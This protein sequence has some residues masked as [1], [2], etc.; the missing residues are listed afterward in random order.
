MNEKLPS[1]WANDYERLVFDP[2]CLD[3]KEIRKQIT[4]IEPDHPV[5]NLA[6][7]HNTRSSMKERQQQ[8][9]D[10]RQNALRTRRNHERVEAE[11]RPSFVETAKGILPTNKW[12]LA[13]GALSLAVL[14]TGGVV[15]F[16]A[17]PSQAEATPGTVAHRVVQNPDKLRAIGL[18]AT[19]LDAQ[20]SFNEQTHTASKI[21][22]SPAD[23]REAARFALAHNVPCSPDRSAVVSGSDQE[24]QA[25]RASDISSFD[26]DKA[27]D[28]LV[29][30]QHGE[31]NKVPENNPVVVTIDQS[32]IAELGRTC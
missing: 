4:P 20:G 31:A 1:G 18:C 8:K 6:A 27:C 26:A 7:A 25:M 30:A 23:Y 11:A 15:Y 32:V 10:A 14:T 12:A 16:N 19:E 9:E 24:L 2:N 28:Q 13:A 22:F 17:P 21:D 5:H 29:Q 3:L